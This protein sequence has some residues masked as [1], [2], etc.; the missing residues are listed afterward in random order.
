ML[1]S[2]LTFEYDADGNC[3]SGKGK[4]NNSFPTENI[5]LNVTYGSVEKHPVFNQHFDFNVLQHSSYESL[6]NVIVDLQGTKYVVNINDY[7]G[8]DE[9]R[10]YTFDNQGYISTMTTEYLPEA[11]DAGVTKYLWVEK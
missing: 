4:I 6:K 7:R 2:N 9:T 10:K 5:N 11:P 1:D 8:Y 3:I